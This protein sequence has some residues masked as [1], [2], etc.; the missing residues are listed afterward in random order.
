[1]AR[2]INQTQKKLHDF[3]ISNSCFRTKQKIYRCKTQCLQ[4][5]IIAHVSLSLLIF[6]QVFLCL[7]CGPSCSDPEAE[8]TETCRSETRHSILGEIRLFTQTPLHSTDHVLTNASLI[9]VADMF[10]FI[11]WSYLKSSSTTRDW[12]QR[13][14]LSRLHF[15]A[16]SQTPFENNKELSDTRR[17]GIMKNNS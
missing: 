8:T 9:L 13:S 17:S 3:T 16:S 12:K 14:E 2:K 7:P 6:P 10:V 5:A 15:K 11:L 4:H 1:M